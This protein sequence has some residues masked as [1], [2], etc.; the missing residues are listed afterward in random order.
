MF[1]RLRR[2]VLIWR[3]IPSSL[4]TAYLAKLSDTEE[5]K[6]WNP[7][8]ARMECFYKVLPLVAEL[9]GGLGAVNPKT[10]KEEN[11]ASNDRLVQLIAKGLLYEGCVDYCQSQALQGKS[12]HLPDNK[13]LGMLPSLPKPRLSSTDLSLI[14]WLQVLGNEQF[15]VPFEQKSLELKLDALK[16]PK[17]EAQWTDQILATPI[18]PGGQFPHSMVP[19][20][21]L[22][23][24][25]KQI[26]SQS[27]VLPCMFSSLAVD[28]STGPS[29]RRSNKNL[30]NH[31]MSQSTTASI[32]SFSINPK[33]N[34][35]A[36][37]QT[38]DVMKQSQLITHMLEQNSELSNHPA[39]TSSPVQTHTPCS[40]SPSPPAQSSSSGISLNSA[41]G[42]MGSMVSGS[43]SMYVGMPNGPTQS[44]RELD[45]I[46]RRNQTQAPGSILRQGGLP[47][48]PE[49][50][51][52]TNVPNNSFAT[53]VAGMVE[54]IVDNPTTHSRLFHEFSNRQ[55]HRPSVP[56]AHPQQQYPVM[57]SYAGQ[58]Y[59]VYDDYHHQQQQ[60]MLLQQQQQQQNNMMVPANIPYAQPQIL[61]HQ[62]PHPIMRPSPVMQQQH[63]FPPGQPQHF[64]SQYPNQ[65]PLS[66]VMDVNNSQLPMHHVQQR[67]RSY[68]DLTSYPQPPRP[69]SIVEQH[70]PPQ[71][72][73]V[74]STDEPTEPTSTTASSLPVNF[75]PLCRYEDSQAIRAV[76]FHPSG[77]Y[78]VIGTN[79]KQMLVCKYPD[80]RKID[81]NRANQSLMPPIPEVVLSRPKQHRGSVYCCG[82]N[83]SGELLA[84]GSNDKTL[85]LMA[86]NADD[87]KI[88][89]LVHALKKRTKNFLKGGG[90]AK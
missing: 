43:Q 64:L 26:M 28:L 80:L 22:K 12:A 68:V 62:Q 65:R 17:L 73:S 85:R 72:Q 86:F 31:A 87:C 47:P 10:T 60:A 52:P 75:V 9:L 82:F 78:F 57:Q 35:L 7:S 76:S 70:P 88:G 89:E 1:K 77:K 6:S 29:N 41:P 13:F 11:H 36:N 42:S 63:Q 38:G 27:M 37:D 33:I 59:P 8:N 67:P 16:K 79:S 21:K 51:T 71:R 24:A 44:R 32:G 53:A 61:A 19:H 48:V 39:R 49:L 4:C 81:Q 15:T 20:A 5:L 3:G 84:T 54:P 55:T 58:G 90:G 46:C 2:S 83:T 34:N 40:P 66:M 45:A 50:A 56:V 18:K 25:Q 74:D 14:S 30:Y 23:C 69:D